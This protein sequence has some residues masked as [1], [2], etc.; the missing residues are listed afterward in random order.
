MIVS[1]AS[2][3]IVLSDLDRWELLGNL[4][5]RVLI[6]PQVD[7]ELRRGVKTDT[8]EWLQVQPVREDDTLK[9]LRHLLDPGESEAIALALQTGLSLII[10]EKKGRAIARRKGVKIMGLLGV[11]YANARKGFL[12]LDEA[13]VF[14]TSVRNHGF[15]I[16][17]KLIDALIRKLKGLA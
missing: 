10:D 15:R 3:L 6:P 4:F 13:E 17:P 8:P 12:A 1:D 14:M 9:L 2:T 5:D 11:V 7:R 16:H